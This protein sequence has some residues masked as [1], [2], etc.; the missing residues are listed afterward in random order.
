EMKPA[1]F[2]PASCAA[3]HQLGDSLDVSELKKVPRH[4]MLP[5]VLLDLTLQELHTPFGTSQPRVTPHDPDVIPHHTTQFVPVVSD[6][7][8]L[9]A[10]A[11]R[12][13]FPFGHIG[14]RYASQLAH[15]RRQLFGSLLCKHQPFEKRIGRQ[16][17]SA[18]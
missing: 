5:I 13:H 17:V 2:A 18:V 3:N 7:N 14:Q 12:T 10:R 11:G 9:I 1:A 16:P 15:P 8:S 6:D 4:E